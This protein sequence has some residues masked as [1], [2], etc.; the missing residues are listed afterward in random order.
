MKTLRVYLVCNYE[1]VAAH[2]KKEALKAAEFC[3]RDKYE[4]RAVR[5]DDHSYYGDRD[6]DQESAIST[7][8]A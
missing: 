8:I 3:G 2:N 4:C 1:Y 5:A 6:P 7:M